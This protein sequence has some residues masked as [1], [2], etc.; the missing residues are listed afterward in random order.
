MRLE[1]RFS[2]T[3]INAGFNAKTTCSCSGSSSMPVPINFDK[4]WRVIRASDRRPTI[5]CLLSRYRKRSFFISTLN[6]FRRCIGM[7]IVTVGPSSSRLD[8]NNQCTNI[9]QFSSVSND[10]LKWLWPSRLHAAKLQVYDWLTDW[11]I[12]F[13]S[14]NRQP[15]SRPIYFGTTSFQPNVAPSI[16]SV[17]LSLAL[18][19]IKASF[20]RPSERCRC[21]HQVRYRTSGDI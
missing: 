17:L 19:H 18:A 15:R 13:Y 4:A 8:L 9:D 11:S 20:Q 16:P 2:E 14:A 12:P 1:Y 3:R 21:C 10:H 7:H 5:Q 6:P